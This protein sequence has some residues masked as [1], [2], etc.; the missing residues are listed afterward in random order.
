[1]PT[2]LHRVDVMLDKIAQGRSVHGEVERSAKILLNILKED[3][4]ATTVRADLNSA[5]DRLIDLEAG[6]SSWRDFLMRLT[7]LYQSL[8]KGIEDIRMQLQS[9]QAD[10]VCDSNLPVAAEPAAHFLL[11]LRV[12]SLFLYYYGFSVVINKIEKLFL[13][14]LFVILLIVHSVF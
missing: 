3:A 12:N 2:A 14:R 5:Q 8:E 9:V 11:T 1:M 7:R 6:L 10:L 4:S 13:S